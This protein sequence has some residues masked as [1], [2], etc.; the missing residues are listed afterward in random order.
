MSWTN[1]LKTQANFFKIQLICQ[2]VIMSFCHSSSHDSETASSI[3]FSRSG[4]NLARCGIF[5]QTGNQKCK[6]KLESQG[7]VVEIFL[8]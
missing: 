7:K 2:F 4:Q 5:L 3:F 8:I 6:H 1:N